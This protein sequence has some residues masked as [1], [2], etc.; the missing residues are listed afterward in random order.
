MMILSR[1]TE[2]RDGFQLPK[3]GSGPY[4]Y[5][6]LNEKISLRWAL[7]SNSSFNDFYFNQTNDIILIGDFYNANSVGARLTFKKLK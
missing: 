5:E 1:G 3:P 6:L 4:D 2:L 7:S